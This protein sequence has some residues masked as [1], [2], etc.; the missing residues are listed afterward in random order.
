MNYKVADTLAFTRESG[1]IFG[2]NFLR[3]T[4]FECDSSVLECLTRISGWRSADD[5]ARI[6]DIEDGEDLENFVGSLT[7]AGILVRQ[8]TVDAEADGA[9][10]KSW[11]WGIPAAL[12]HFCVQNNELMPVDEAEQIQ[13]RK[14]KK[15][16]QPSLVKTHGNSTKKI[17]LSIDLEACDLLSVMARR[18]TRRD[19][20]LEPVPLQAVSDC[21]FS[22][23]GVT[24]ETENRAGKLPL[25][26]TPS[27]GARN[28][29]EAYLLAQNVAHLEA[30]I[31][32]YSSSEHSLL[33]VAGVVDTPADLVGGQ[34]WVNDMACVIFLCAHFERTMWKYSDPNAYRVV[35]IEA[36]H[37]GQNIMLTATKHALTACPTA[38]LCHAKVS[39]LCGLDDPI[40]QTPVYAL[41]LG[42]PRNGSLPISSSKDL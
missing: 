42:R 28:P 16:P 9:F 26:M 38:A 2:C 39:A 24:G 37:I 18:R 3:K 35:M 13:L 22:G 10:A 20:S 30:G 6:F 27:G 34:P 36:G 1:A 31:Y 8:D 17:P 29:F 4:T 15:K 23:F 33:P 21:L 19:V 40:M 41:A 12:M 14:A 11:E 32:H 5:I 25:T 7:A